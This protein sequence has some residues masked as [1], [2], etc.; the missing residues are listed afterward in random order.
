MKPTSSLSGEHRT[1]VIASTWFQPAA[2][3]AA[4]RTEHGVVAQRLRH[5]PKSK[6]AAPRRPSRP[7]QPRDA[8]TSGDGGSRGWRGVVPGEAQHPLCLAVTPAGPISAPQW[9]C[10]WG[11]S[12]ARYMPWPAASRPSTCSGWASRYSLNEQSLA[13]ARQAGLEREKAW[14]AR[15]SLTRTEPWSRS[16]S[17]SRHPRGGT[18]QPGRLR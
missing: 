7:S 2:G 8:R 13:V 16:M 4:R 10:G 11:V 3:Q 12:C 1:V 17:R 18:Q 5:G 15:R 6:R 9:Q 14:V